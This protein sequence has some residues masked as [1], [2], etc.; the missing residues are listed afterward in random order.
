LA[1]ADG[2]CNQDERGFLSAY[3]ILYGH[4]QNYESNG[5]IPMSNYL[6]A[7]TKGSA[8]T[9]PAGKDGV[10]TGMDDLS[11][12]ITALNKSLGPLAAASVQVLLTH[13]FDNSAVLKLATILYKDGNAGK[14]AKFVMYA[15]FL[16][17]CGVKIQAVQDSEE[18]VDIDE[19][20]FKV[21]H[22]D[23]K[24]R[25]A[26][27]SKLAAVY[28]AMWDVSEGQGL[29]KLYQNNKVKKINKVG[30]S[31]VSNPDEKAGEVTSVTPLDLCLEPMRVALSTVVN[32]GTKRA[33]FI[34]K[35]V[36][37]IVAYGAEMEQPHNLDQLLES[38]GMYDTLASQPK[39]KA[40]ADRAVDRKSAVD[41]IKK[42][43]NG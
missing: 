14:S 33:E 27:I 36:M 30:D 8:F 4:F 20:T 19:V 32:D 16:S 1:R 26:D 9:L 28:T 42:Q 13:S 6:E 25:R 23:L 21:D 37:R 40:L 31:N 2:L 39:A 17:K 15:K 5:A 34:M 11:K 18:A 38:K 7:T 43:A 35:A 24:K 29:I 22:S 10:M 41:A 12:A 3:T